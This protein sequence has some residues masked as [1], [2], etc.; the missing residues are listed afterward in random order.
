MSNN[1]LSANLVLKKRIKLYENEDRMESE[2][3]RITDRIFRLLGEDY[4]V[5]LETP[6]K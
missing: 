4:P 6:L 3:I 5:K 2:F 1:A